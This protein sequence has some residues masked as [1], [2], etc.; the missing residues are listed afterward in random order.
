MEAAFS[1]PAPRTSP[2]GKNQMEPRQSVMKLARVS[3]TMA[4]RH[5]DFSFRLRRITEITLDGSCLQLPAEDPQASC[6]LRVHRLGPA[7]SSGCRCERASWHCHRPSTDKPA[8]DTVAPTGLIYIGSGCRAWLC[9]TRDQSMLVHPGSEIGDRPA[10][11]PSCPFLGLFRHNIAENGPQ[12]L[13]MLKKDAS[14]SSTQSV[15][16]ISP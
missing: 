9:G 3:V 16:K 12:D 4:C 2:L 5:A 10:D 1:P 14:S 15:I 13:K 7:W 11:P 8:F 6:L